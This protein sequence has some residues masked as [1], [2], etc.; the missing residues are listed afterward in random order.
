MPKLLVQNVYTEILDGDIAKLDQEFSFYVPGFQ[1]IPAY[2]SCKRCGVRYKNGYCPKCKIQ[3]WWDGKK[4]LLRKNGNR[5]FLPTGCLAL[6][7]EK[8]PDFE[9]EDLRKKP[10]TQLQEIILHDPKNPNEFR[11]LYPE[12]LIAVNTAVDKVRGVIQSPT[13]SGKTSIIAGIL[14]RLVLKAAIIIHNI[15]IAKQLQRELSAMLDEPVGIIQGRS[16]DEQRVTV[17]MA[18]TLSVRLRNAKKT[19]E[20]EKALNFIRSNEILIFDEFHHASSRTW[21]EL[22]KLF[23]NAYYRIGVTGTAMMRGGEDLLAL[24]STGEIIYSVPEHDL[25]DR[26]LLARPIIHLF[27][28]KTPQISFA[29][30]EQQT[31][32]DIY[33]RGVVENDKINDLAAE[34]IRYLDSKN[35]KT[36][37]LFEHLD[38]VKN[39][40]ARLVAVR[41][42]TLTGEDEGEVREQAIK[43]LQ[44]DEVNVILATRIFDEG[45]DLP[46]LDA[47]VRMGMQKGKIKTKQQIGRGQ[48]RKND[49]ENVV[50]VFDFF[51][52]CHKKLQKHSQVRIEQYADFGYEMRIE[53][54]IFFTQELTG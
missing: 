35:L 28:V 3:R 34:I 36:L 23:E 11:N 38:H 40:D 4:H 13:G 29:R 51:N 46:A 19:I 22:A 12:Q 42:V 18:Q 44:S 24:A 27:V 30:G 25:I 45:V 47:V 15:T 20:E 5:Y 52:R 39:I 31:Y 33:R 49:K 26:G 37:V 41:H 1:F 17:V 43:A 54:D 14:K 6:I 21:Y 48:R 7:Q 8:F 32:P 50:H 10:D 16:W 2:T 9:I 53:N